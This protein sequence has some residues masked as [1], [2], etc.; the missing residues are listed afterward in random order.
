M[1][2]L[3]RRLSLALP[4][5]ALGRPAAAGPASPMPADPGGPGPWARGRTDLDLP[6]RDADGGRPLALALHQP[7]DA[8]PGPR[9]LVLVSHGAGG[10][11]DSHRAQAEHLASHGFVVACVEH[12]ASGPAR[13]RQGGRLRANLAAMTSDAEEVLGRP[14]DLRRVLDHLL[15]GTLDVPGPAS[16]IDP[17]RIA[18]LGHSFGAATVL[19]LAGAR[20]ALDG[21]RPPPPGAPGFGPETFEPRLRAVIALSPQPEAPPFFRPGSFASLRCPVLGLSGSRDA[22]QGDIGPED[23]RAAFA[24]WPAAEGR[25]ALVWIEGAAHLD[26]ADADPL[27]AAPPAAPRL[28]LRPETERPPSA[29]GP[30]ARGRRAVQP[31]VRAASLLYLREQL[32]GEVAAGERLS[33]AGLAPWQGGTARAVEVQRR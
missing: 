10:D 25:H 21:L 1:D 6:A 18:A 29:P 7:L 15:A 23:R 2:A 27:P 20:V 28:R 5:A 3:R 8:P 33:T 9:P 11:R 17:A 26:F 24:H 13:L 30:F 4:L 16:R 12:P 14:Q 22:G 32:F 31:L 19:M